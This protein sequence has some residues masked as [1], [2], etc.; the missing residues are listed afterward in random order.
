MAQH[1]T[2]CHDTWHQAH[3]KNHPLLLPFDVMLFDVAAISDI[4][5]VAAP[6]TFKYAVFITT[7]LVQKVHVEAAPTA[8]VISAVA[9]LHAHWAG[10]ADSLNTH[11]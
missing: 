5:A 9:L 6:A 8:I 1:T 2:A 10:G 3:I 11:N 4:A 7:W